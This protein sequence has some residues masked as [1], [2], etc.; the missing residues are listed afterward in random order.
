MV[1]LY[2]IVKF[3][4][5]NW[6]CLYYS[7]IDLLTYYVWWTLLTTKKCDNENKFHQ[8]KLPTCGSILLY[9]FLKNLFFKSTINLQCPIVLGLSKNKFIKFWFCYNYIFTGMHP[10]FISLYFSYM[11]YSLNTYKIY[12]S[13]SLEIQDTSFSHPLGYKIMIITCASDVCKCSSN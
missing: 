11:R 13:D 12:K 4:T 7:K 5:D 6:S 10:K 9:F 3:Q 8:P 1:I 2:F